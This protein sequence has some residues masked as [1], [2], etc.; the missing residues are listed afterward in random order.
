MDGFELYDELTKLDSNIS[1]FCHC[2]LTL[3]CF[4]TAYEVNYQAF[5]AVFPTSINTDDIRCFIRKPVEVLDFVRSRTKLMS[6]MYQ[7]IFILIAEMPIIGY[8]HHL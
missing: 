3:V 6:Y 1:M 4:V 5:R 7:V 8:R 2:I